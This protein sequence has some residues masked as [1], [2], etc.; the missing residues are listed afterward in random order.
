MADKVPSTS[1]TVTGVKL[2]HG[3]VPPKVVGNQ[4]LWNAGK[5]AISAEAV[6]AAMKDSCSDPR[7]NLST[8]LERERQYA[9]A[10][11]ALEAKYN[12]PVPEILSFASYSDE[13]KKANKGIKRKE[14]VEGYLHQFPNQTTDNT[15][16]DAGAV[17]EKRTRFV[18]AD[19][20]GEMVE[21]HL[22]FSGICRHHDIKPDSK[23]VAMF[24]EGR[25]DLF[26]QEGGFLFRL[27][28]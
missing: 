19:N 12:K 27:L 21:G 5:L 15:P 4:V 8:K 10:K 6:L 13:A 25:M 2:T 20:N 7:A 26:N 9:I 11:G 22:P 14:L 28:F 23:Y 1:C 16:F 3:V 18:Y 17:P 24:G